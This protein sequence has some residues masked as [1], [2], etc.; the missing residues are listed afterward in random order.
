MAFLLTS[1]DAE[2][3]PPRQ[4]PEEVLRMVEFVRPRVL[5]LVSWRCSIEPIECDEFVQEAIALLVRRMY[6]GRLFHFSDAA[7]VRRYLYK[8]AVNRIARDKV[9]EARRRRLAPVVTGVD[10][11]ALPE[12]DG[13]PDYLQP[14][15]EVRNLRVLA[16]I[17]DEALTPAEWNILAERYIRGVGTGALAER[18]GVSANA[19]AVRLL[20]IKDKI[21]R[22]AISCQRDDVQHFVRP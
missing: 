20:R 2:P 9:R 21:R 17:R 4:D 3:Q 19:M 13:E 15:A 8:V 1:G 7:H 22:K 18:L 11:D 16:W 10:I 5:K 14:S 12:F 6:G